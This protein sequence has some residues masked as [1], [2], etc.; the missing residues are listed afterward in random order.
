MNAYIESKKIEAA[1]NVEKTIETAMDLCGLSRPEAIAAVQR[2][3]KKD[4]SQ[5]R[6]TLNGF[7]KFTS[8]RRVSELREQCFIKFLMVQYA[9]KL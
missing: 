8:D 3:C 1:E 2:A 4:H 7:P 9:D 5:T 6:I